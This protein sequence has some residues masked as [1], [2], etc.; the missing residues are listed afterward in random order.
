MIV[1]N[2]EIVNSCGTKNFVLSKVQRRSSSFVRLRAQLTENGQIFLFVITFDD[3]RNFCARREKNVL[4]NEEKRFILLFGNL[5][6][7]PATS[8]LRVAK[9]DETFSNGKFD[10]VRRLPK[11]FR[12]LKVRV[13]TLVEDVIVIESGDLKEEKTNNDAKRLKFIIVTSPHRTE[14]KKERKKKE[15]KKIYSLQAAAK[16]VRRWRFFFF[17]FDS[18]RNNCTEREI[19]FRC[20][21]EIRF[22]RRG[23]THLTGRIL[24]ERRVN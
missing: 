3:H 4:R 23:R 5:L 13:S 9:R 7:M 18:E 16:N 17:F 24:S 11:L 21:I 8:S 6:R 20:S 12:C 10:V 19:C 14:K 2:F 22:V 1:T 15:K